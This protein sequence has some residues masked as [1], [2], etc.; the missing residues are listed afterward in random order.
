[1]H[2]ATDRWPMALSGRC[3]ETRSNKSMQAAI[4]TQSST[5]N[6]PCCARYVLHV[7][8]IMLETLLMALWTGSARHRMYSQKPNSAPTAQM[9]SPRYNRA[10][11]LKTDAR[12]RHLR[13]VGQVDVSV[14]RKS[15]CRKG[16]Y[17]QGY[18]A[19]QKQFVLL[20]NPMRLPDA[21][22]LANPFLAKTSYKLP[23]FAGETQKSA[24]R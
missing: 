18:C 15:V 13:Q 3:R 19:S 4:N 12:K 21:R 7:S 9:A 24:H 10:W 1:M 14:T 5:R 17:G 20:H 11:P 23:F 22:Q 6:F 2:A 8:Q 16:H